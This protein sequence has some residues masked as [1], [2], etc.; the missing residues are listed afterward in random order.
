LFIDKITVRIEKM[1][2]HNTVLPSVLCGELPEK[3]I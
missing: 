1:G 2:I 3:L